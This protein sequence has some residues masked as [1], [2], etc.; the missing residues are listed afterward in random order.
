M[1]AHPCFRDV[2]RKYY[3]FITARIHNDRKI[4]LCDVAR[5]ELATREIKGEPTNNDQ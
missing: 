2:I 5:S 3:H 1:K 4:S